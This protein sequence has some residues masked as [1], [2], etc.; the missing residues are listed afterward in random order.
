[1]T[2]VLFDTNIL[3]DNFAGMPAAVVE[4]SNYDDAIISS[5]TWMEVACKMDSASKLSF[6]ALLAAAGIRVVHP[7]DDI[8]ERT[9]VIRGHSLT[10]PPKIK[11][12]D[13]IIR[14]TAESQGRLVITRNPVDFGGEGLTVRVPY[15]VVDGAAINI[16]AP[17][18]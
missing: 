15:D 16:K 7:N 17:G 2:I 9:A 11:L 4:L 6:N 3:I 1:M 14:A 10:T 18:P 5:I 13:C 8:M 12:L